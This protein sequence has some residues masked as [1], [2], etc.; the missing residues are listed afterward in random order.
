MNRHFTMA[1]DGAGALVI[2]GAFA[3]LLP[4]IAAI[5]AGMWYLVQIYESKTIQSYMHRSRIRRWSNKLR[6]IEAE[7]L[8]VLAEL[9]AAE[10]VRAATAYANERLEEAKSDAGKGMKVNEPRRHTIHEISE[11]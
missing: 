1:V 4:P 5:L 2:L 3:Q 9:D 10:K 11:G 7:R 8:V 6:K